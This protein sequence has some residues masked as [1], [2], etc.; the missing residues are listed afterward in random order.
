MEHWRVVR[1]IADVDA[2]F[3]QQLEF[4]QESFTHR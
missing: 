4:G 1:G 3:R 2:R